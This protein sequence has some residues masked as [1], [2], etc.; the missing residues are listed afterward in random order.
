MIGALNY[1]KKKGLNKD[2]NLRCVVFFPDSTQNYQSKFVMDE[3]MVGNGFY[4][5]KVLTDDSCPLSK[6]TV[7]DL[8]VKE[9]P[10]F[11]HD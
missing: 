5:P 11:N 8:D 9:T 4:E 6:M 3:W 10:F 2:K 1:L 7:S